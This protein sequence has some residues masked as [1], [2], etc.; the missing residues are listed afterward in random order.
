MIRDTSDRAT[1]PTPLLIVGAHKAGTT[2]LY[3]A[4][5]R[6]PQIHAPRIKEPGYFSLVHA[7]SG[8][9]RAAYRRRFAGAPPGTRYW[10]D[11][12]TS[13]GQTVKYP[14]IANRIRCALPGDV[15]IVFLT[16]DP[17][18]RIASGYAE[19]R[20][21]WARSVSPQ[22]RDCIDELVEPTLYRTHIDA[23][24]EA[25][26]HD[27]VF[28]SSLETLRSR[29]DTVFESLLS[30]LELAPVPLRLPELNRME[31]KSMPPSWADRPTMARLRRAAST[32]PASPRRHLASAAAPLLRHFGTEPTRSTVT[33]ADLGPR[34]EEVRAEARW[35]V[36][37]LDHDPR[38]PSLADVTDSPAESVAA[39]PLR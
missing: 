11:G 28:L 38:W 21:E 30:W 9:Q 34:A 4:L 22:L 8:H 13:Y 31:D 5:G 19:L 24:R 27:K 29:P 6:H 1:E 14:G 35:T 16:R 2:S 10:L 33:W 39:S 25:F 18:Q 32:I 7:P 17:L 20:S 15:R 3:G 36:Q 26:G 12:S 23:Y 37:Q